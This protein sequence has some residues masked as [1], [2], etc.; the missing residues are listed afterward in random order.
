V[1]DFGL[2]HF[3]EEVATSPSSPESNGETDPG[4][5]TVGVGTPLYWAPEQVPPSR[6]PPDA[7]PPPTIDH[8]T[9][10]WGLGVTLYELLTL[11]RPFAR[12]EQ[13]LTEP[14]RPP[15]RIVASFPRELAA[16]CLR[17]L[18][19]DPKDRYPTAHAVADDLRRWLEVRPTVAGEAAIRRTSNRFLVWIRIWLRRLGYWSRRQPAAAFAVGQLI[20]ILLVGSAIAA[21]VN[22]LRLNDAR[23]LAAQAR[24]EAQASKEHEQALQREKDLVALQRLRTSS[25]WNG[26]SDGVWTKIRALRGASFDPL[27]QAQAAASLEGIDAKFRKTIPRAF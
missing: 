20:A 12:V 19:K 7:D 18:E 15:N 13:I 25:H 14:P 23:A 24:A 9:D 8:R 17:A 5:P 26:W 10:V 16:V 21:H 22:Q 4:G 3:Q 2:A 1:L 27:L 6:R 11:R